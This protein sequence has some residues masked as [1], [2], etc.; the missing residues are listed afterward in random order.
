MQEEDP[1]NPDL[2]VGVYGR[3]SGA[4]RYFQKL[5]VVRVLRSCMYQI[6]MQE[7]GRTVS[8]CMTLHCRSSSRVPSPTCCWS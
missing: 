2:Q 3:R 8:E 1:F 4:C 5:C 7:A 6:K